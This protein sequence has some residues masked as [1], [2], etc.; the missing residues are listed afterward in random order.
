MRTKKGLS[1][2]SPAAY[3]IGVQGYLDKSWSDRMSGVS[4]Q[5]QSQPDEAPVTVLTGEF[6]DQAALSGVLNTLY[7]LGFPLLCVERLDPLS[8]AYSAEGVPVT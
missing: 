4:I 3:K 7:D 2:D 5:V 1:L 8:S 6:Q